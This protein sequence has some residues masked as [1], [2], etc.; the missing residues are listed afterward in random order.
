[1]IADRDAAE[2][3][4]CGMLR[5]AGPRDWRRGRGPRL[6]L[7][8]A[9]NDEREIGRSASDVADEDQPDPL[10]L[11]G[12]GGAVDAGPVVESGLRLLEEDEAREPRVRRGS[13]GQRPCSLVER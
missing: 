9:S 4:A 12:Q 11:L 13:Q 7:A 5:P 6:L 3:R 2:R 8:G 1:M 10:Q